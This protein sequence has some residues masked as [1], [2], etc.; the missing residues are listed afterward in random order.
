[1]FHALTINPI[2]ALHTLST[3]VDAVINQIVLPD[4]KFMWNLCC[5]LRHEVFV[6][7]QQQSIV[8]DPLSLHDI[9]ARAGASKRFCI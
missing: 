6:A 2:S 3:G 8:W 4:N 1:M 5:W 9:P 7:D